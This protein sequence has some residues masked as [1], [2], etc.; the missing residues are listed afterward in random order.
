MRFYCGKQ[1]PPSL[2][3]TGWTLLRTKSWL[4]IF[5]HSRF[6]LAEVTTLADSK[7]MPYCTAEANTKAYLVE[8]YVRVTG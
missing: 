5:I 2:V 3:Q 4:N 7:I 6:G 1:S 8:G